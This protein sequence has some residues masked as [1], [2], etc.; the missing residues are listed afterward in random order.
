MATVHQVTKKTGLSLVVV[1]V[2]GDCNDGVRDPLPRPKVLLRR[3]PQSPQNHAAD[4]LRGV[5]YFSVPL[6]HCS[7]GR[8]GTV[9]TLFR[10]TLKL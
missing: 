10:S 7:V 9:S 5:N 8:E 2:G 3:L 4:L 6:L 1:E